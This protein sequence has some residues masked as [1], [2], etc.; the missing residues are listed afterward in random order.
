MFTVCIKDIN[1]LFYM[2]QT[3]KPS[4]VCIQKTT[5]IKIIFFVLNLVKQDKRNGLGR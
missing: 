2:L 1:Y 4:I 5:K 3:V